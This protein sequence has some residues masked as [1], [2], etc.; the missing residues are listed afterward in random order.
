M[1]SK[2]LFHYLDQVPYPGHGVYRD[3]VSVLL[4]TAV[5]RSHAHPDETAR[6]IQAAAVASREQH[7]NAFRRAD[8]WTSGFT[9]LAARTCM[10]W[11]GSYLG[12]RLP[13]F[14]GEAGELDLHQA[15]DDLS[16]LLWGP[17]DSLAPAVTQLHRSTEHR[18]AE[19][20]AVGAYQTVR[21]LTA[22]GTTTSIH[23]THSRFVHNVLRLAL[24]HDL[25]G[26]GSPHPYGPG[27]LT[28]AQSLQRAMSP[29]HFRWAP[30]PGTS[31]L[32][33]VSGDTSALDAFHRALDVRPR[34]LSWDPVRD[35]RGVLPMLWHG[36]HT[37][38]GTLERDVEDMLAVAY[39]L[40]GRRRRSYR[41]AGRWGRWDRLQA[42]LIVLAAET[43]IR[44]L[45]HLITREHGPYGFEALDVLLDALHSHSYRD[46]DGAPHPVPSIRRLLAGFCGPLLEPWQR[47]ALTV[48]AQA[49]GDET[50]GRDRI[51]VFAG[52]SAEVYLKCRLHPQTVAQARREAIDAHLPAV[53][54]Q[55]AVLARHAAE[56][57]ERRVAREKARREKAARREALRQ[58]REQQRA[59]RKQLR[60]ELARVREE[61]RAERKRDFAA[62]A[63]ASRQQDQAGN[64]EGF[65]DTFISLLLDG[66]T[67][68]AALQTLETSHTRLRRIRSQVP[69]ARERITAAYQAGELARAQ[70][71]VQFAA[72]GSE[73]ESS[74]R[75][76]VI[77]ALR[78]GCDLHGAA[79][80]AGTT[81]RWIVSQYR[82]VSHFRRQVISAYAR[83]MD[84]LLDDL[85]TYG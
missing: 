49:V 36:P 3:S 29:A 74:T 76:I 47:R 13:R 68:L 35:T 12:Y 34:G 27:H 72:S 73:R 58:H 78:T 18:A 38:D 63:A 60:D 55:L 48:I 45:S 7:P 69:G 28:L 5:N 16:D 17:R 71:K 65:L 66:F 39:V 21:D 54:E 2:E 25:P 6:R 23:K 37:D 57:A 8:N 75:R 56:V 59:E 51:P 53:T 26:P 80:E 31:G 70:R 10:I 85:E 20:R 77:A 14:P 42:G 44:T 62:R 30:A 19:L 32:R 67:I 79:R 64:D 84:T 9:V 22:Y 81:P 61:E 40:G 11:L 46:F 1:T 50:R 83:D 41:H 15:L 24:P 82:T 43:S 4:L 52:I 33:T